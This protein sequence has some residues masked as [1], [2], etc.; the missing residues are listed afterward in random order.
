MWLALAPRHCC[1]LTAGRPGPPTC[2]AAEEKGSQH[3]ATSA[4]V[5]VNHRRCWQPLPPRVQK[6]LSTVARALPPT[7]PSQPHSVRRQWGKLHAAVLTE[8]CWPG[9]RPCPTHLAPL[10]ANP[11]FCSITA[12]TWPRRFAASSRRG[13]RRQAAPPAP[14][15]GAHATVARCQ[16]GIGPCLPAAQAN[17]GNC[18]AR[19]KRW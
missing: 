2:A 4:K 1:P 7:V 14:K 17:Q 5:F 11:L 6:V 13:Y 15:L 18:K 12:G 9:R 10:P 8:S 3:V 19:R 16:L